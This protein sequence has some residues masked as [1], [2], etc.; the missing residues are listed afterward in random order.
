M[1]DPTKRL[2]VPQDRYR[3]TRVRRCPPTSQSRLSMRIW[4]SGILLAAIA[5]SGCDSNSNTN[6][7]P[8]LEPL[9]DQPSLAAAKGAHPLLVKANRRLAA[10]NLNY[11]IAYAEY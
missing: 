11:R 6:T 5:V 1:S 9:D 3:R 7:S 8:T 10:R 2:R 4:I